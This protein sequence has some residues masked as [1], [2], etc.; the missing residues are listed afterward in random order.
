LSR[1]RTGM[2]PEELTAALPG[3]GLAESVAAIERAA[4]TDDAV[5]KYAATDRRRFAC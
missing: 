3:T 2:R 4:A 5:A 1:Q